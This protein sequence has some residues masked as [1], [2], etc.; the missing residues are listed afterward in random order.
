MASTTKRAFGLGPLE[1]IVNVAWGSLPVYVSMYAT[2]N[3]GGLGTG[4]LQHAAVV[5]LSAA[6]I[7]AGCKVVLTTGGVFGD[8]YNAYF[9]LVVI[10]VPRVIKDVLFTLTLSGTH[11]TID[12]PA[13][14]TFC[15]IYEFEQTI[16]WTGS[17]SYGPGGIFPYQIYKRTIRLLTPD[18]ETTTEDDFTLDGSRQPNDTMHSLIHEELLS[19]YDGGQLHTLPLPCEDPP[20]SKVE[21]FPFDIEV[22][23]NPQKNHTVRDPGI[24]DFFDPGSAVSTSP[25][26]YSGGHTS[27]W[28][29]FLSQHTSPGEQFGVIDGAIDFKIQRAKFALQRTEKI[30][31]VYPSTRN[32]LGDGMQYNGAFRLNKGT[33]SASLYNQNWDGTPPDFND[34]IALY[35]GTAPPP[36]VWTPYNIP[37]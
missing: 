8:P 35:A 5:A 13:P 14:D 11:Q 33:P 6:A 27:I 25:V 12:E 15:G 18:G 2:A 19:Y 34:G 16:A 36:V 26:S 9:Q 21:L 1:T 3:R 23:V 31:E 28:R 10:K 24:A 37:F 32:T 17:G 30:I 29:T 4:G 22:V 20:T 7:K